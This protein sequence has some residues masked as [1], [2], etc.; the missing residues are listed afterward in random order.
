[1]ELTE[2]KKDIFTISLVILILLS[3][4]LMGL[5]VRWS[6]TFNR[7]ESLSFDLFVTDKWDKAVSKGDFVKFRLPPNKYFA[8]YHWT[9][10]IAGVPGDTITVKD[11]DVYINDVFVGHAKEQS[12]SKTKYYP[13]LSGIIPPGYY[14]MQADH[15]DSYDSRYKS[16]GLIHESTFIGRDYPIF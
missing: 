4:L 6:L 2:R 11:R 7:T 10:R 12:A 15:E 13:T 1:M 16:F 14:Y 8:Q 5:S 9:K 3:G